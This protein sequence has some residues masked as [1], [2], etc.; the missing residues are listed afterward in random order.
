VTTVRPIADHGTL[1]RYK[2]HGCRCETCCAG[3]RAYQRTTRRRR[4]YGTWQP[5]VGAEPVRQHIIALH[6]A[7]MSYASIAKAAG[8]YEATVTG[9]IYALSAKDPRKEKATPDIANSI[10]AVTP[11]P[12]LSGWIDATGTRRRIQALAAHGWPMPSL[13][14]PIGINTC[15]VNR[16]T[17]Q[18][19][20][21]T[22]TARAVLDVYNTHSAASPQEHGIPL[23]KSD[24]ARREAQAKGW[25]D[26]LWWEDMG[27]IDDPNFDP[28]NAEAAASRNDVAALRRAEIEHLASYGYE[29]ED[30][31]ARVGMHVKSTRVI[32]AELRT[33]QR[34]DRSKAAA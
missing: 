18:V 33:G 2:H 27:H 4:G 5:F 22:S 26:P 17:R 14:D 24:R 32:L 21:F 8:L 3:Y 19:R 11:D 31:A 25:P 9:F 6:N 15:S 30:I 7:G 10:L 23:W 34:R 20:V 12:M 13:A 16:I 29:A 28:A 1:S